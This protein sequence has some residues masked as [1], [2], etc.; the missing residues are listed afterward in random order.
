MD[1]LASKIK[2]AIIAFLSLALSLDGTTFFLFLAIAKADENSLVY[3]LIASFFLFESLGR[4][5]TLFYVWRHHKE[6]GEKQIK[7][8]EFAAFLNGI[9]ATIYPIPWLLTT[10]LIP[11]LNPAKLG[12]LPLAVLFVKTSSEAVLAFS[13]FLP[14]K[15][16]RISFTSE[17]LCSFCTGLS[18]FLGLLFPY[19]IGRGVLP[20]TFEFGGASWIVFFL[21]SLAQSLFFSI[22][23][24]QGKLPRRIKGIVRYGV[25]NSV[26]NYILVS[27]SFIT[28]IS[29][30]IAAIETQNPAYGLV[31][32]IYLTLAALRLS[33]LLWKNAL[34][35]NIYD[36]SLASMKESKICVYE[37][38]ALIL[39]SAAFS[40]GMPIIG[41]INISEGGSFALYI[42]IAYGLLRLF[43]CVR[44]LISYWKKRQPF[45]LL[46]SCLD[47][48]VGGYAVFSFILLL[49]GYLHFPYRDVILT[50]M[51][52]VSFSLILG[53]GIGLL[54]FGIFG[55]KKSN[56]KEK[57]M[58]EAWKE[59]TVYLAKKRRLY[60]LLAV[61]GFD[62][63]TICPEKGLSQEGDL[64][65]PYEEELASLYQ[66][67]GFLKALRKVNEEGLG[68]PRRAKV[69]R[70]LQ[71]ETDFM[72]KVSIDQYAKWQKA[73][74]E[75]NE[76]WRKAKDKNDFRS[77]LP[78]WQKCIEAKREEASL[79]RKE[80]QSLYDA[81]L[82][83][84]EPGE[85]SAQLDAIFNPLK[86][87]LIPLIR[88]NVEASKKEKR[89]QIKDYPKELQKKLADDLLDLIH[90]D[91]KRGSLAESPHPFSNALGENDIRLTCLYEKDF[92]SALFTILHEGGHCLEF[93]GW[94]KE[95]YQDYAEGLATAAI[96]ETHS[97][98]YENILGRSK[99][100]AP[101]L[102]KL[103]AKDL[104]PE[105]AKMT[106]EQF[107]RLLN[108]VQPGAIRCDADELTY[109]LHIIIR[110]EIEKDLINGAIQCEDVPSIW[111]RKYKE[112]LGY[113]VRNDSEGCL[114]DIHWS[115]GEIGYFPSYALGNIYG[116]QILKAMEKSFDIH[117][118]VQGGNLKP[119]LLWLTEKDFQDDWRDPEE[120]LETVTKEKLNP[121]YYFDYLKKKFYF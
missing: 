14:Y 101:T 75:S 35:R 90:F 119:V 73:Y 68:N 81:C 5:F 99:E 118:F 31:G 79:R 55:W 78:K 51:A 64:L 32:W 39:C 56:R 91:K 40:T 57:K 95:M 27:S 103:A 111:K 53:L 62:L 21:C 11:F 17:S 6:T 23:L 71:E 30:T 29:S 33:A 18:F 43:F 20:P 98:F 2:G 46:V 16:K 19:L 114:Q 113:E 4:G 100:L 93:Q 52:F 92:R 3:G 34:H 63:Q 45:G 44:N 74:R 54:L 59:L 47:L 69:V 117:G 121:Q 86:E 60:H 37:G 49:D 41:S 112:Y 58:E 80:G 116:A 104:D 12:L 77:Y 109:P 96:C 110:Y 87:F 115:D 84:Y 76:A 7:C 10:A 120:W 106:D 61:L 22:L 42:Q 36:Q 85:T 48:I 38:A 26:G 15:K 9:F 24:L 72:A 1:S 70:V 105:F 108:E 102:K 67:E 97:R 107:Y 8:K 65:A 89:P 13:R 25:K 94:G 66:E 88:K 82:S 83:L 28:V 50:A